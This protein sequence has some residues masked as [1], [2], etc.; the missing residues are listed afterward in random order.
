MD[1]APEG[2]FSCRLYVNGF[3]LCKEFTGLTVDEMD[4][5]FLDKKRGC[6]TGGTLMGQ[7]EIERNGVI[8]TRYHYTPR[9]RD[10]AKSYCKT[11]DVWTDL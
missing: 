9:L 11:P 2:T 4:C 5:V 10:K 3:T 8:E 6:P 1:N 7:C